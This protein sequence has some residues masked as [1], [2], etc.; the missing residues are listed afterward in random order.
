MA[1]YFEKQ[2]NV[3]SNPQEITFHIDNVEIKL[4]TNHG[5]FNKGHLDFGTKS[6]LPTLVCNKS[7]RV[8]DLGCGSGIIGIYCQ[9]KFNVQVDMVDINDRAVE[10]AL[11][12][13]ESNQVK[14]EVYQSD[15]FS[16]ITAMFDVV[17]QNPPIHAGKTIIYQMFKEVYEH[18]NEKGRFY[19][20][21]HKK[22]GAKSAISYIEELFGNSNVLKREKGFYSVLA[23]KY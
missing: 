20:V 1:H 3:K 6:L 5:L 16:Q 8:L 9:K 7:D 23:E 10:T 11:N 2:T 17:I 12:N 21:M 13:V 15:G 14:A 22:H 18:L 19:F 4:Q